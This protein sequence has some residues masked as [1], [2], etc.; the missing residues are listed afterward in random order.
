MKIPCKH[1]SALAQA[2]GDVTIQLYV[3]GQVQPQGYASATGTTT[4]IVN[5]SFMT[6]VQ[7]CDC[8]CKPTVLTV[9]NTA[10][11]ATFDNINLVAYK[12][13]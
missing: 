11:T 8:N 12:I 13:C 10:Q 5:L 1:S 6:L 3:N 4:D 2:A 9:M 7:V